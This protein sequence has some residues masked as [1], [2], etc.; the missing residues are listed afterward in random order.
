MNNEEQIGA[1]YAAMQKEIAALQAL[2]KDIL[3]VTQKSISEAASTAL[4]ER[5]KNANFGGLTNSLYQSTT[6]VE[7][8]ASSA[9]Q[10]ASAMQKTLTDFQK[11]TEFS[12]RGLVK[13]FLTIFLPVFAAVLLG[14]FLYLWLLPSAA[15]I[16][17]RRAT[18]AKLD[19]LGG[20][21]KLSQCDDK[22]CIR[23]DTKRV[24]GEKGDY[25]ILK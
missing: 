16:D 17:E 3:E 11:S 25:L 6:Q 8:A 22:P 10:T 19:A 15:D 4:T 21:A 1:L 14:V 20:K 24:Y 13:P 9:N 2:R 23:V 12:Y 7:K 5:L 18:I